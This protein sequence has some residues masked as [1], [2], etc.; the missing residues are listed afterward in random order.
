MFAFDRRYVGNRTG[1]TGAALAI[2]T[3][4]WLFSRHAARSIFDLVPGDAV[5]SAILLAAAATMQVVKLG[6]DTM[7]NLL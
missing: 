3:G 5:S 2:A 6:H 1:A 7:R 4:I